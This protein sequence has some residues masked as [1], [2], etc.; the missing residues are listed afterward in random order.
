[1]GCP[2]FSDKIMTG[3]MLVIWEKEWA[4]FISRL[5]GTWPLKNMERECGQISV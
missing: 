1:M 3:Q 4:D 2:T 5:Q